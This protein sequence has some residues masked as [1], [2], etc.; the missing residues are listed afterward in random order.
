MERESRVEK[1]AKSVRNSK[2]TRPKAG[3]IV[4]NSYSLPKG[5]L[6]E[7]VKF[8]KQLRYEDAIDPELSKSEI[9]RIGL[10]LARDAGVPLLLKTRQGLAKAH[11]GRPPAKKANAT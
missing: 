7:L 2:A 11:V 5:E 6:Q 8:K 10:V 4:R 1:K 3:P 9:V